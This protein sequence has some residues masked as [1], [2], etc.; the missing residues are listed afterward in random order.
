MYVLKKL[1]LHLL[2][3][4]AEGLS[5]SSSSHVCQ[6]LDMSENS[7]YRSWNNTWPHEVYADIAVRNAKYIVDMTILESPEC[8]GNL[9]TESLKMFFCRYGLPETDSVAAFDVISNFL[10]QHICSHVSSKTS[11]IFATYLYLHTI[12][13]GAPPVIGKSLLAGVLEVRRR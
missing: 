2:T 1:R 7:R 10:S 9:P 11:L 4:A 3:W 12:D 13:W 6:S 8:F 5:S